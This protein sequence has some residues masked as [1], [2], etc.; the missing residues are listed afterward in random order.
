VER[1]RASQLTLTELR[2][3]AGTTKRA[4]GSALAEALGLKGEERGVKACYHEIESGQISPERVRPPVWEALS[5][6]LDQTPDRLRGAAEAG[7]RGPRSGDTAVFAFTR[8]GGD[9]PAP[10]SPETRRRPASD[11]VRQAFFFDD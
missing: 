11:E 7:F 5:R 2:T 6:L 3:A 9:L 1:I 4:L 8:L 10:Q